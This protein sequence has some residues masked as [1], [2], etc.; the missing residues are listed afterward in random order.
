MTYDAVTLLQQWYFFLCLMIASFYSP[1]QMNCPT[2]KHVVIRQIVSGRDLLLMVD[3]MLLIISCIYKHHKII[4]FHR[5]AHV[6]EKV[7]VHIVYIT[8]LDTISINGCSK[9]DETR[10]STWTSY[11]Y[12]HTCMYVFNILQCRETGGYLVYFTGF[13]NTILDFMKKIMKLI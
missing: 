2:L 13:T 4:H 7:M 9:K 11:S 8:F 3:S 12:I 1:V 10:L 6:T 5:P